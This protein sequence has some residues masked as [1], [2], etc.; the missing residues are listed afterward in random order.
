VALAVW[1]AFV[2]NI[3]NSY[4][5]ILTKFCAE[6][7]RGLRRNRLDFGSDLD[8]LVDSGS[9]FSDSFFSGFSTIA[10]SECVNRHF[11]AYLSK[12]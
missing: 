2:Q 7:E 10:N 12:L 1:S 8:S 6:V 11:A 4:E 5:R 9:F 3:S